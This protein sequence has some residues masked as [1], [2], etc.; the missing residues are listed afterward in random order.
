MTLFEEAIVFAVQKHSGMQRK[1]DSSP[2][3]LHPMEAALIAST[4]TRD[5]EVLSAAVLHDVVEDT[6]AELCDI[7]AR[8]GKRVAALVASETENKRDGIPKSATW[9][10]RKHE[11]LTE[12]ERTEDTAVK[13]LWLSDKLSNMRA[14]YR[15]W[16][17]QGDEVWKS[18]NQKDPKSHAWYYR[19][20]TLLLKE[21]CAYDAWREYD[22]LVDTVFQG[23]QSAD[24]RYD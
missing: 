16:L 24:I 12:L 18:F 6:D 3:I 21:L 2:Y 5:E 20:S 15:A 11:S 4:M 23:V 17:A 10:I 8:F 9:M 14:L 13:I 7:E 22:R 1:L 19:R